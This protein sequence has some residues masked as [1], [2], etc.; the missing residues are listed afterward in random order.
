MVGY[1]S[2]FHFWRLVQ[3]LVQQEVYACIH[4]SFCFLAL[5]ALVLQTVVALV[6]SSEWCSLD[7]DRESQPEL[8]GEDKV[9]GIQWNL[10][11][12]T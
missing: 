6:S 7:V 9:R 3:S 12:G 2:V 1:Q 10:S 8:M 5:S 4:P 11:L